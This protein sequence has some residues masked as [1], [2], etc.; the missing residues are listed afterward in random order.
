MNFSVFLEVWTACM[1]KQK[2]KGLGLKFPKTQS[3]AGWTA[4]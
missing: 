1:I 4:G 3:Q 2:P